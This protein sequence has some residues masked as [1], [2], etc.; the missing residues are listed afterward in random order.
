MIC[1]AGRG[2]EALPD[3]ISA[4]MSMASATSTCIPTTSHYSVKEYW[5]SLAFCAE[6]DLFSSPP[7]S[8]PLPSQLLG[9]R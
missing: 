5:I 9:E 2:Q 3:E 1:P 8:V 7:F 4:L 6:V